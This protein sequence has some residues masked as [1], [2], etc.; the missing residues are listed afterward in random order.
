MSADPPAYLLSLKN[1]IRARPIPWEGA[2]RAGDITETHLKKIRSADKVRKDQ[3]RRTV[4]EDLPGFRSLLLG[5]ERERSVLASAKKRG[6]VV[7]YILVLAGDLIDGENHPRFSL[8]EVVLLRRFAD[9]SLIRCPT[10]C[11]CAI[12]ASYSI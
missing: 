10:A 1:N 11:S 12:R 8:F 5:S 4:E 3:R 6:D 9:S 7:Q 2:V